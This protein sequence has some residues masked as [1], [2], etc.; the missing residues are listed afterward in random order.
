MDRTE[1]PIAGRDET[2]FG[3]FD[4]P[5]HA[6]AFGPQFYWL[7]GGELVAE[8]VPRFGAGIGH[9]LNEMHKAS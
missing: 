3:F 1:A 5:V 6:G 7:I 9:R 2:D 4:A 8:A